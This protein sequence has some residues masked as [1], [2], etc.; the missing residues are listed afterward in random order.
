MGSLKALLVG[1][2]DGEVSTSG[3]ISPAKELSCEKSSTSTP[4][5]PVDV[6]GHEVG[7]CMGVDSAVEGKDRVESV[8]A[9]SWTTLGN[10][11]QGGSMGMGG[12]T[13][14]VSSSPFF[15]HCK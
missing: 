14:G 8:S 6:G 10:E 7:E 11:L 12:S 4:H 15:M 3:S 1:T 2:A 5:D 13:L 9:D